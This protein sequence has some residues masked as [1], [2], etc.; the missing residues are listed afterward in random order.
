LRFVVIYEDTPH[1][2]TQGKWANYWVR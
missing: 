2:Y 1:L